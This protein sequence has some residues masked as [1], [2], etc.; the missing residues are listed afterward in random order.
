M[1]KH[2][3]PP[4]D[5]RIVANRRAMGTRQE[6]TVVKPLVSNQDVTTATR[7]IRGW[8]DYQ[9]TRLV[10][11]EGIAQAAGLGGIWYKDEGS[12]FGVGSFKAMGG[13][14]AVARI[15]A[16]HVMEATG[17]THMPS[18][19]LL[20]PDYRDVTSH[21]TVTCATD[22]NHGR[23]VSW[24]A[25][26]FGCRAVVYMAS[27]VSPFR[28]EAIASFGA[29][30]IRSTGTH[31]DAARECREAARSE[32]WYVV[33]ETE[34][35]TEPQI[36]L[37]TLAG[38][39]SLMDEIDSQLPDGRPPTHLF[40]QA[41][42]GGLAGTAA[43]FAGRRWQRDKPTVVVVE[44]TNADCIFRSFAA[45]H[46]VAV[47]G[48]LET[49]MA[50]LAAGEVSGYAWQ[51]L[52]RGAHYAMTID[53]SAAIET[54]RLLAHAPLGDRPIA[55]GESGV[56][57]LA[58]ALLASQDTSTRAKLSLDDTS[59]VVVIGTEGATDPEVYEKL[60]GLHP[61]AVAAEQKS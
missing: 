18:A 4:S 20:A 61:S 15:V 11:L 26:R 31:E 34:N 22:G 58:A 32:G 51:L 36:A 60:V 2:V 35:A 48:A 57:G 50:G 9:P 17:S 56:A 47:D 14:Y 29:M 19:Q 6:G 37:D 7:D 55:S 43:A 39:S 40:I 13:G 46:R 42:V 38:Y 27:I 21:V 41:G 33:S 44:A 3:I 23:A 30:T 59:R 16:R 1:Q 49:I 28:E 52:E 10:E 54:M 12:R 25:R 8:P 24:A 45:G 53:D 5:F